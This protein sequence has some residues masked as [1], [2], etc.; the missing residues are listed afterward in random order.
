MFHRHYDNNNNDSRGSRGGDRPYNNSRPAF[1]GGADR[2]APREREPVQE[3]G[4]ATITV[5]WFNAMKG[6]GFGHWAEK[7]VDVFIPGRCLPP[8]LKN[9]QEGHALKVKLGQAGKGPQVL[10]LIED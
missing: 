8:H 4:E 10:E 2:G 5:K 7:D 9:I 1:G 3:I 6:Y